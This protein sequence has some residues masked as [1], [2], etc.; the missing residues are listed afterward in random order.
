MTSYQSSK[1]NGFNDYTQPGLA[2][3]FLPLGLQ[4][5][6]HLWGEGKADR[7]YYAA[8][9]LLLLYVKLLAMLPSSFGTPGLLV[10]VCNLTH[11]RAHTQSPGIPFPPTALLLL[12]R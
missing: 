12:R 8:H 6:A 3:G 10:F 7:D 5:M 11:M 1:G 2:F 4:F 9:V